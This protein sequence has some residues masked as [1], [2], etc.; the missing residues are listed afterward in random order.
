MSRTAGFDVLMGEVAAASAGTQYIYLPI[1]APFMFEGFVWGYRTA[2][3]NADNTLDFVIA[4]DAANDDGTFDG[5]GDTLHTNANAVG[6]LNSAAVGVMLYNYGDAASGGGA[7]VAVTPTKA[8]LD[9]GTVRIAVTTAGTGTIPAI[10][11]GIV[12]H[13]LQPNA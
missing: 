12:G 11:F 9:A 2:E 8:R 5:T 4:Q 10:Q 1:V 6:L 13:W 7:A 3:A